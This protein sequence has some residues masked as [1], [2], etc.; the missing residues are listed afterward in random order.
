MGWRSDWLYEIIFDEVRK[1]WE[2]AKKEGAGQFGPPPTPF[3]LSETVD[4]DWQLVRCSGAVRR[5]WLYQDDGP[6]PIA[7]ASDDMDHGERPGMF[8]GRGIVTFFIDCDRKRVLFTYTLGPRY[9]RGMIF[10]VVGQGA[11]GR[12]TPGA[13]TGWVS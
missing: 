3:F 2:R 1:V 8:Y 6:E 13:G 7:H 4:G 11:R 5:Q 9:S 12:L 10:H